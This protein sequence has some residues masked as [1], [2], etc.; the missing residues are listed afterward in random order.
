MCAYAPR[1]YWG[2]PVVAACVAAGT[3]YLDVSGE[4]DFIERMELKVS[5]V[6]GGARGGAD[7]RLATL[8]RRVARTSCGVVGREGRVVHAPTA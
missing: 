6:V 1:S 8:A 4:P 7:H 3:D 5:P 2:E